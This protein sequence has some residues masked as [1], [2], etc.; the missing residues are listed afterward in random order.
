M[1]ITVVGPGAMG[2]LF[3]ARLAE[4]GQDVLLL[5]HLAERTEYLNR[6]GLWIE[7]VS[8]EHRVRLPVSLDPR[9]SAEADLVLICVKAYNTSAAITTLA[10]A[11]PSRTRVLT[12]QNGVGN[13]ETLT[14]ACGLERVWGGITSHGATVIGPGR[15]RHAGMG[16]TIIGSAG[17]GHQEALLRQAAEAF[18]SAGF[19]TSVAEQVEP[20]IWSKLIV[21]VGI[22]PL[23]AI[24][25]LK[26]GQLLEYAGTEKIM[27]LA[28]KEALKVAEKKGIEIIFP[29]PLA[30]VKKVAGA[31]AGNT[32]SMLQDVLAGRQ[33]EIDNINGA[34][35]AY[36][37][38]LK[39][40][41][42]VNETLTA[43]VK[44][45]ESSAAG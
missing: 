26:N 37:R 18:T 13:V 28:V 1:K 3:A 33:T 38:E 19:Q 29:D 21:N 27:E 11:L 17:G 44:T 9:D 31:T 36:G 12:L 8:G 20:L 40:P 43:L 10:S 2:C 35:V 23:A 34:I 5:D 30:H 22:N 7:G 24:T 39:I 6:E 15:V 25:R 42:P 41:T 45:I 4:S 32:A 16:E 14:E